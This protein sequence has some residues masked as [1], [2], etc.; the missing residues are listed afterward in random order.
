MRASTGNRKPLLKYP[1]AETQLP[2]SFIAYQQ[3]K[4][5]SQDVGGIIVYVLCV[6]DPEG[7]EGTQGNEGE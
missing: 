4:Q 7:D 1:L 3:Q 6:Q 5:S 2:H